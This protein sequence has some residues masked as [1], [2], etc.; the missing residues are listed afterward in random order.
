MVQAQIPQQIPFPVHL[1]CFDGDAGEAQSQMSMVGSAYK[2]AQ[3]D[4]HMNNCIYHHFF[5]GPLP[6]PFF[7][8]S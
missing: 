2:D 3:D 7:S 1:L 5:P 8:A 6:L 4:P